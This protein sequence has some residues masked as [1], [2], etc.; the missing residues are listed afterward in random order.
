MLFSSRFR[1]RKTSYWG[2]APTLSFSSKNCALSSKNCT[3]VA[4]IVFGYERTDRREL[5]DVSRGRV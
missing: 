4:K 2:Q 1:A 3:F 5:E